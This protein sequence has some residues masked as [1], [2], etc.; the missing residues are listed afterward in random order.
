MNKLIGWFD[1]SKHWHI[2]VVCMMTLFPGYFFLELVPVNGITVL[3]LFWGGMF[4]AEY[5]IKIGEIK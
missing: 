4:Y 2:F 5:I 3:P 1:G